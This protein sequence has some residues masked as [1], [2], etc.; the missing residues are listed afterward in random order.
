VVCSRIPE[1]H[2]ETERR[3]AVIAA[4]TTDTNAR[5][6]DA[7]RR[8]GFDAW[9]IAPDRAAGWL[10]P[11]DLALGRLDVLPTF[12]GP[13]PGLEA[14]RQLEIEPIAVVNR[15][16]ALLGAHDK[17]VTALRLAACSLPHPM[18]AHVGDDADLE[19]DF[20]VVVKPRFGSWGRDVSVCRNRAAL[21]CSLRAL[22]RRPWFVRQ[23]ALVQEL[24]GPSSRDL[25]ILVAAGEVVGSIERVAAEGEWRT[26]VSLG[27]TR[28]AIVP[29][30]DACYLALRAA[31]AIG[32]DLVGVDLLPDGEGGWVVLELN[33]AVDFTDD[34]ALDGEN[35]FERVVDGLARY[36]RS[37]EEEAAQGVGHD[38]AGARA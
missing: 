3:L 37:H 13:E 6:V 36:A 34:Y 35:V 11:G 1:Q 26:N 23:G 20:P 21:W 24:V 8:L 15:A 30:A 18:T 14:L 12:D 38:A 27:G 5:L 28:R 31:E 7:A 32:T 25:R 2:R 19:L 9:R 17:L 33:G 22:R 10:G 16:G 29:P 4:R